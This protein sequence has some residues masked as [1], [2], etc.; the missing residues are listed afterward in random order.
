MKKPLSLACVLVQTAPKLQVYV[1]FNNPVKV[2]WLLSGNRGGDNTTNRWFNY[3]FVGKAMTRIKSNEVYRP[4]L[5]N[6][7]TAMWHDL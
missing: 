5:G 7:P 4:Q 3:V 6:F 2:G 1:V